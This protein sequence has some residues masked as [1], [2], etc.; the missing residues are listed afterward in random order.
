VWPWVR[1]GID[2]VVL[3]QEVEWELNSFMLLFSAFCV[4]CF[5]FVVPCVC[6]SG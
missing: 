2:V 6:L 4:F 3:V 1:A 5:L